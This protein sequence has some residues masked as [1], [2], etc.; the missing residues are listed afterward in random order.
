M[1]HLGVIATKKFLDIQFEIKEIHKKIESH[2]EGS[3]FETHTERY[4]AFEP[5]LEELF[6]LRDKYI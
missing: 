4:K 5:R 3:G 1:K 6:E 2:L